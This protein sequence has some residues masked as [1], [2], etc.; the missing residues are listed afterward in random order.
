MKTKKAQVS[1]QQLLEQQ[2]RAY[3]A[4]YKSDR[5]LQMTLAEYTQWVNGK[6]RSKK[7][8]STVA[9]KEPVFGR[10]VWATQDLGQSVI[11]KSKATL[12]RNSMV[13]KVAR[14]EIKGEDAKAV[15]AKS[16]RIG[17]A[18]SKGSYQYITEETD[19]KAMGKKSQALG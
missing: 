5:R 19:L 17:V 10:P 8:K 9:S 14:G 1:K 13:E 12:S 4:Q 7:P 18:F 2:W 6:T 15:I 16:K 3:N 11:G